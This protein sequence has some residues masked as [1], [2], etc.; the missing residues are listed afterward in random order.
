MNWLDFFHLV[1]PG[2]DWV[3]V[4]VTSHCNAACLYC[5]HTVYRSN[6]A[7][8]HLALQTFK[9]LTQDFPKTRM[10]YLQGWG[11]P[12]LNPDFFTMATL[13]REAGCRVGVTTN[14]MLLDR[15]TIIR[16]VESELDVVAFSLAGVD[17]TQDAVRQGTRLKQVM[18]AIN[19]LQEEKER[20]GRHKP[21]INLA[22]MLLRSGLGSL[23]RL[24]LLLKSLGVRQVV[25]S[26]L[27]FVA[28]REMEAETLK[29]ESREEYRE[30]ISRLQEVVQAG[31]VGGLEIQY[32]LRPP[33]R[34]GRV[35]RENVSRAL[36]VG[37]GGRVAPC[38]YANLPVEEVTYLA[39]G[40]ECHYRS[41]SF[42]NIEETP[43]A[44]IWQ[45]S[46]YARFRGSFQEG[47]LAVPCQECAKLY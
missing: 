26:T 13:A 46:D 20:R 47:R 35:C 45:Q 36:V 18:E 41:L 28:A 17:E 22:Y 3:Q 19:R 8:R 11:E 44:E 5:P 42:G 12:F 38:A 32:H 4:E 39:Q 24:P 31:A 40:R 25:I 30:I 37:A 43:L 16:I 15:G 2:F 14:G 6:W 7:S 33:G 9:K 23:P 21:Q 34:K 1:R 27:D 10:V 29:P